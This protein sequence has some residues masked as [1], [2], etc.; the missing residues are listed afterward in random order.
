MQEP[1]GRVQ[2]PYAQCTGS[3]ARR[4]AIELSAAAHASGGSADTIRAIE[5]VKAGVAFLAAGTIL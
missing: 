3:R 1:S 5:A 4:C 2:D